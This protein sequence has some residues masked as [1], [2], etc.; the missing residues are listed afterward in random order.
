M[1]P[2]YYKSILDNLFDGLYFVNRQRGITY[3]NRSAERISGY[4]AEEVLGQSCANNIL[5][6]ITAEGKELCNDGCPLAQTLNNGQEFEGQVFLL[7][8]DGHRVPVA[9]RVSPLRDDSGEIVGAMEVFSDASTHLRM[10]C[11]LNELKSRTLTDALTGLGNRNAAEQEFKRRLGELKRY[12]TPFGLL[13]ADVDG[14]KSINDSH[15]HEAG[16]KA[17]VQVAKTLQSALRG[18]DTVCRWGGEEFVALV[19]Q[20]EEQVFRSI[21]ERMR[22]FVEVSPLRLN[23]E[24]LSITVS[25]GGALAR[26]DDTLTSLTARADSMMYKAKHAGR[27]CTELDCAGSAKA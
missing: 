8:K 10:L 3:W 9:V 15:G 11:E 16:D 26:P 20:V 1:K 12:G 22:R 14:F 4:R 6:H 2:E 17:L 27:N 23:G 18:V 19:P 7:H 24:S 21:A 5:R 13:F 25:V